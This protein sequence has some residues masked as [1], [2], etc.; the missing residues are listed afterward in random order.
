MIPSAFVWMDTFA[1]NA[2][3]KID[4]SSLPSLDLTEGEVYVAP[5][6]DDHKKLVSIWSKVLDIEEEKISITSDFFKL[7]GHSLLAITLINKI[8]KVFN[9][10]IAIRDFFTHSTISELSLYI[11][12]KEQVT[13]LTIPKAAISDYY[14]LSSAQGRM[15]FLYEFDKEGTV[16]NMPSFFTLNGVLDTNRL[17][18]AFKQLVQR[19]QSLRTTFNIIDDVPVQRIIAADHF[20]VNYQKG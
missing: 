3:G 18:T 7:G 10:E 12:N 13:F 19:H 9:V 14:P 5:Q 20:R 8:S 6:K 4:K 15:Y 2:N 16:Y 1:L 17:E 11:S